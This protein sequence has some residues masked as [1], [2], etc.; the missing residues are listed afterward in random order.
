MV[1]DPKDVW[2]KKSIQTCLVC[3]TVVFVG[4]CNDEISDE[5]SAE[6]ESE[7]LE[8]LSDWDAL[9]ADI[10]DPKTLPDELKADQDFS[11]QYDLVD[12][13]SSVKS[14]GSRGVCSI[15]SAVALMEHL[16]IKKGAVAPDFSEQ[17][18]Q[19][20][21]KAELG[22]FK[23]TSGSN[24]SANLSAINRFGI[25]SENVVPYQSSPW[26]S[27]Q[28]ERCGE[29]EDKRPM[30]CFTNGEPDDVAKA[31]ERFTLPPSR[32]I[33]SNRRNLKAFMTENETGVVVGMTFFYQ[34]WNHRKSKLKVN[35]E[36]S[37]QGYVLYPNEP[38]KEKSLEKRAGHSILIVGWDDELE[39]PIVDEEGKQVL[40][41][42]G[43]PI[44]EKGF[45]LF[46]NSWGSARF[47][48]ANPHGPGYGWLSM[49]YVEEYGS[50]VST[51][52]PTED[53]TERCD[54]G[55]DNNFDGAT[56][57]D[58]LTCSESTV[59]HVA[60]E[61][62]LTFSVGTEE[63]VELLDQEETI[64]ILNVENEGHLEQLTI[65]FDIEHTFSGDLQI[66]LE[67]PMG[68]RVNLVASNADLG[69]NEIKFEE[70]LSVFRGELA[71]GEWT[72]IITDRY[73]EDSG[74]LNTWSISG[75]IVDTNTNE[76]QSFETS[77]SLA[78][79]D[80]HSEG[81]ESPLEVTASGT[82]KS[83][84][85]RVK[86]NHTYRGDLIVKLVHP[87]G[88]SVTLL[89]REGR[90]AADV[91]LD[92]AVPNFLGL[93][94]E[95]IWTLHVLDLG[96]GDQGTLVEWSVELVTGPAE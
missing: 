70:E 67:S 49:R 36:Y 14:Q 41:E 52:P 40:D 13:Q 22:R 10:P 92:V 54:D 3:L 42:E 6:L 88:D 87:N 80:H 86:I 77:P 57:C 47:G 91:D 60:P 1:Q 46:K 55:I 48:T 62:E 37:R 15:F 28:D 66:D 5:M 50:T 79:P 78:I 85:A 12:L 53:L 69:L 58:D 73:A 35:S 96:A 27:S 82:I 44:K 18:L 81:I 38:D 23:T 63:S 2:L 65:S 94:A 33:S 89:D 74:V 72:L 71:A 39:V 84:S 9:F 19:W 30:V 68:T 75:V 21:V 4:A 17:F 45:F 83:L 76:P 64:S 93:V 34:S 26:S 90:N 8:T 16:Y 95:G 25:V 29:E 7:E 61:P 51:R 43:N 20:S 24:G 59:C 56:D 32:W 31:A 11:A